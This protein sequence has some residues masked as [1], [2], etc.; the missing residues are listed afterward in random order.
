MSFKY[1]Q[2]FDLTNIV[3]MFLYLFWITLIWLKM[4]VYI[5]IPFLFFYPVP[6]NPFHFFTQFLEKITFSK[7]HKAISNNSNKINL[8]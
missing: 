7:W 2:Y 6:M 1:F 8:G 5:V 3:G 4:I